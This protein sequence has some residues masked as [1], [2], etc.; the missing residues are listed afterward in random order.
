MQ[1]KASEQQF[2]S[3][4]GLPRQSLDGSVGSIHKSRII[5]NNFQSVKKSKENY[6]FINEHNIILP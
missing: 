4:D 2:Q 5:I 3:V 6:R 1:G